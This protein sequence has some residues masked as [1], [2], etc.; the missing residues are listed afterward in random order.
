[1]TRSFAV[2]FFLAWAATVAAGDFRMRRVTNASVLAGL[3]A[4]V[5]AVAAHVDP[6]GTGWR[7][8]LSGGLVGLVAVSPFFVLRVMGAADVKLFAVLGV[9]CGV[10]PLAGL[11]LAASVLA[12]VHAVGVLALT[13][14]S[15]ATLRAGG[16]RTFRVRGFRSAPYGAF[17]TLSAAAWLLYR[18]Y[19]GGR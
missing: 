11:W 13:R 5:V 16:G 14:T 6:F 17:L 2:A 9:W 4:G 1:M 3:G 12:G 15:V 10:S 18:I 8:A 7:G 19:E